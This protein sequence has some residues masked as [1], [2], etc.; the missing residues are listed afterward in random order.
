[1]KWAE[2][3]KFIYGFSVAVFVIAVV[4]YL[5]RGVIA[6]TPTCS[7]NKQ[8]GYESGVDCGGACALRCTA[9][10]QTQR[11]IWA[12]ALET[13]P[14][15]YDLVAFISNKNI[16]SATPSLMYTFTA[17]DNDGNVLI[18][19]TGTTPSLL[20][21]EFPIIIQGVR[22]PVELKNVTAD[23]YPGKYFAIKN[24]SISS[25]VSVSNI[26]YEGG[27]NPKVFAN[28]I[29]TKRTTFT[30]LPV[31]VIL[32]DIEGNAYG[33]GETIIPFLDKESSAQ[34]SFV[35]KQA[36]QNNPVKIRV[37]PI[38]DPFIGN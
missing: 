20:D 28:V 25:S 23:L 10:V 8:N 2:R 17:Y 19:A 4:I 36:F 30:D 14:N 24:P 38:V 16:D 29:N 1:M 12:R 21:G 5:L 18:V 15:T 9:E 26:R 31:R 7:D 32:Y 22:L 27:D 11:I 35:W 33:A 6:P 37:Y 3:R 13:A 34:V